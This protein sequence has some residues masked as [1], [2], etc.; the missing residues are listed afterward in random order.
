ML[1]LAMTLANTALAGAPL[2]VKVEDTRVSAVLLDCGG[3]SQLKAEVRDGLA[4]FSQ[5]P[6]T[7]CTVHMLREVG[8]IDQPGK[9]TCGMEDCA[10]DDVH[11]RDVVNAD[12]RINVILPGMHKGAAIEITCPDGW[13]SRVEL[14]ENTATIENVPNDKCT[15]LVKGG[16]PARFDPITWGTWTCRLTG[17]TAV[18][19]KKL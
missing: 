15:L 17:T 18:C 10:L 8:T 13:R 3:A 16:V 2:E 4:T 11:H 14:V 6:H 12:G 5:I 19:S 7:N 9:W 1:V